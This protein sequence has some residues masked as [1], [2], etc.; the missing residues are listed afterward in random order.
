MVLA[1]MNRFNLLRRK[2]F[3]K[4]IY[5]I[6][7]HTEEPRFLDPLSSRNFLKLKKKSFLALWYTILLLS[8]S[9]GNVCAGILIQKSLIKENGGNC[10]QTILL[11]HWT[12]VPA[13]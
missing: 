9:L 3:P 1:G 6:L 7:V 5:M 11:H 12:C 4:Q 2:Q 10:G 8:I 13:V